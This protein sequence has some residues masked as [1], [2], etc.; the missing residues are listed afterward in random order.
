MASAKDDTLDATAPLLEGPRRDNTSPSGPGNE[1]GAAVSVD[2]SATSTA[3]WF[4]WALT[5]AAGISGF[6]FGYEYV[7]AS[8]PLG[9]VLGDKTGRK[10]AIIVSG[11]LFIIGSLWQGITSTVWGMISGRSLVGLAIG[12]SSLITPLQPGGWRWMV[13]LGSSPGI[14][15]LLILAFLPE[16]PRWLVRANRV[17]EA[18]QIMRRVYGDTKQ[19]NQVVEH[20]LRDIKQ[21]VLH[22]S[23]ETD[24]RPGNSTRA[25]SA[26]TTPRLWL[27]KVKRTYTELFTIGC[28]RRALIIA[29][30]LQGLQQLCGFNSLMYFAATIFKSLSFS[31]PTLTSLSVA[32]TN[33]VFTF[34]AYALIDRIGRRRILLYSIPVMVVSLVICAIAFPSTSL[35]DGGASGTPAPKNS[36]AA[37][38]LLCLTTYTASYASGLGNVPWQQSELFPLSVR[39]LGSALATGTNWGSNFIIGLTFLPMMRWMGA[40]WTFFLYALICAIGWVGIWRIYPEMTG[41][42]L[43]DVRGLLDQ[44]WGVEQSWQIFV[45]RSKFSTDT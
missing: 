29:C 18:R 30:T 25:S 22:A 15:Q 40:G 12:M 21:E 42:G 44:G 8:S 20:I 37:I 4:I 33:F 17:N 19:S 7:Q 24:T 11:V 13:G 32:G 2:P 10:P 26:S 39:S 6:L 28:H 41:L 23:A 5:F 38:I 3:T 27:Q 1:A 34:L 31:S 35:G 45:A 9:G 16:T 36:Q 43:E 14:I